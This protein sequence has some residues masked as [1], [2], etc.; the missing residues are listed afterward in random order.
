MQADRIEDGIFGT[1]GGFGFTKA[2][3]LFVGRVAMLGFAVRP[4]PLPPLRPVPSL[5]HTPLHK[6]PVPFS[7]FLRRAHCLG[8]PK[9]TSSS[10]ATSP[11]SAL[12]YAQAPVPSLVPP[13]PLS[14]C[15][16]LSMSFLLQ[17]TQY[18]RLSTHMH[19]TRG[20]LHTC[21][22]QEASHT[23]APVPVPNSCRRLS[24]GKPSPGRAFSPRSTS[25]QVSPSRRPSP[26]SCSSSPSL[27]WGPS[28]AWGTEA[29]LWTRTPLL[30]RLG[31]C[32]LSSA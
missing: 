16:A 12:R 6:I 4:T 13:D 5:V 22:V 17:D 30:P 29:N 21:T 28:V 2:N 23:H 14:A 1:S 27:S 32:A 3:E 31:A 15:A 9:P 26:F 10:W 18:K 24:W 25:R 19:S 20:T 7:S 11:C 8:S